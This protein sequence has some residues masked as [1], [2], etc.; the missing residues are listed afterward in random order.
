MNDAE[1]NELRET[2]WKRPLKPAEEAR[3]QAWLA[4]RP[5]D[6]AA[7][8]EE[9]SL[10]LLLDQLPQAPVPS[11]F[12]A[13]VLREVDSLERSGCG[14]RLTWQER[15]KP[16][17][18]LRPRWALGLASTLTLVL[19]LAGLHFYR[20]NERK[21]IVSGVRMVSPLAALPHPEALQDFEAIHRLSAVPPTVDLELLAALE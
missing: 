14:G 16:G 15:L 4:A 11:N 18:W 10:S 20:D 12:T 1:W 3:I 19:G 17:R 2:G 6:Q 21:E 5:E 9:T 7:W 13:E 8:E